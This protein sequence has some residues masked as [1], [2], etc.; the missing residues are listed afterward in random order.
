[1][2]V[3][4]QDTWFRMTRRIRRLALRFAIAAL[5][6]VALLYGLTRAYVEY[7][8]HRA[9]SML[10]EAG[11]VQIGDSEAS[12][13]PFV[14]RY[15]G[16]KWILQTRAG[17]GRKEDWVDQWEYEHELRS[18]SD[19]AYFVEVD[20][21][22]F[23]TVAG[24]KGN[25]QGRFDDALRAAMRAIPADVRPLLGMRDWVAGV[26]FS[27]RGGRVSSVAA[28]VIVE[29]RSGWLGHQWT[30]AN[31]MPHQDL[32]ARSYAVGS[33]FM[34]MSNGGGEALENMLTPRASEEEIQAAHTANTACL[35]SV[36]GCDGFCDLSLPAVHYLN[37][38]PDAAPN[39]IP[40]KCQ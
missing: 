26:Q 22:G 24:V 20:P 13:L 12:V 2:Q 35:T 23:P 29:G 28:T 25:Y 36:H 38:H 18:L 32:Q 3:R 39:L 40:P 16:F 5:G 21:W 4:P 31:E 34:N 17:L 30:L 10:A 27:I 8:A 37:R 7:E 14:R 9:T 33:A 11:R 19:Y 15:G 6:L 1:M